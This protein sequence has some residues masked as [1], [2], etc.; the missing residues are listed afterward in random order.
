[1]VCHL[2]DQ[3]DKSNELELRDSL[4]QYKNIMKTYENYD[5][6]PRRNKVFAQ[7]YLRVPQICD[8]LWFMLQYGSV[9]SW[10]IVTGSPWPTLRSIF[11][12]FVTIPAHVCSISVNDFWC[13]VVLMFAW[14]SS[15]QAQ[16]WKICTFTVSH[17]ERRL[18]IHIAIY[19]G[20]HHQFHSPNKNFFHAPQNH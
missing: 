4:C 3:L 11:T 15:L 2:R 9:L 17:L 10:Q 18:A 19:Y 13:T 1:M 16:Q 12:R 14:S 20:I 6:L 5:L 8:G 7:T